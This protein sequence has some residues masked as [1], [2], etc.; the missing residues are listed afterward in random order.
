M[1]IIRSVFGITD[2][3]KRSFTGLCFLSFVRGIFY[4]LYI[5]YIKEMMNCLIN[6]QFQEAYLST[7]LFILFA[8][9][10]LT[11]K[12]IFD[13]L[14]NREQAALEAHVKKKYFDKL[15]RA[16]LSE[17]YQFS[18]SDILTRF[19]AEIS[20]I[21][22]F[23]VVTLM[24]IFSDA[25]MLSFIIIYIGANNAFLLSFLLLTPFII[26]LTKRFGA[27]SR[28]EYK[29]GQD[30][31]IDRNEL[32]KNIID[33]SDNIRAYSAERFFMTKYHRQECR[34]T[35]H[36]RKEAFYNR[37]FWLANI[38]GYQCIYMLF[39]IVGGFLAFVGMFEFGIIVSLFVLLDPL[40]VMIQSLADIS[41]AFYK[42]GV[43][44]DFYNDIIGLQDVADKMTIPV[45]NECQIAFDHLHYSYKNKKTGPSAP[46]L[47]NITM[48]FGTG[49]KIAVIG[50]SG[51]GKSTLLKLLMGYD[52]RY[53]GAIY[54]NNIE[55]RNLDLE[56]RKTI[57]SYLPQEER[58]LNETIED[59]IDKMVD[60]DLDGSK[61][62]AKM[63]YYAA[64]AEVDKEI[65]GFANSYQ[66]VMENG[67]QNIS[68]GQK[69]RICLLMYLIKERPMLLLDES[70]SAVDPDTMLKIIDNMSNQKK[71]GMLVVMHTVYEAVLSRFDSIIIM[72][73]GR[74][75]SSGEYDAV[76]H[77]PCYQKL[78]K[79]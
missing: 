60:A 3:R 29:E 14:R 69:Q 75:V 50:E 76:K 7:G 72:E 35:K 41:P 13:L 59:N 52:D 1:K 11:V 2:M 62:H 39:Y 20:Q 31:L 63:R 10:Q 6:R 66:T 70:F 53:E 4:I 45:T 37:I 42:A 34:F 67:G 79:I 25:L 55:A 8:L 38:A 43:S 5:N 16:K 36:K 49:Q 22:T 24:D 61:M 33:Y 23:N 64:M 48:K 18:T 71:C 30:A 46:V 27:K 32:A 21:V 56:I 58:F 74:I 77:S 47:E 28:K 44:I 15:S 73:N 12:C 26:L 9:L 78:E 54:I 51:S 65:Q 17:L 57:F 19:D 40:I 68:T